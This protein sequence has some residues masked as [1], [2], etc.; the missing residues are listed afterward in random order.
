MSSQSRTC[1]LLFI[2]SSSLNLTNFYTKFLSRVIILLSRTKSNNI[3]RIIQY[4][5]ELSQC[6]C[7][8]MFWFFIVNDIIDEK[9]SSTLLAIIGPAAY[10]VIG[11]LVAPSKPAEVSY[12]RIIAVMMEFY[13]RDVSHWMWQIVK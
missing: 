9:K 1:F 4:C 5:W 2:A 8:C 6:L 3:T 10:R 13:N 11:N 12:A 7:M